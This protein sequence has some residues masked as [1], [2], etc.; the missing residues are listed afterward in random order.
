[1]TNKAI[2][3][4]RE[5]LGEAREIIHGEVNCHTLEWR[6]LNA[7]WEALDLLVTQVVATDRAAANAAYTASCLANGIKPD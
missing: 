6:A 5:K 1:M 4:L 2:D 3:Q 7:L